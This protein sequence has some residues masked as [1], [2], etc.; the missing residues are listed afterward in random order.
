MNNNKAAIIIPFYKDQLSA[1]EAIAL[2]QC[3]KLLSAYNIIAIKPEKL[4]LPVSVT[5]Y[6]FY[7]V[8]SFNDSYFESV[9]GYNR[10]MLSAE[11]YAAFTAYEYMLIHQLDAFVFKDE[12]AYWCSQGFDYIGAP[13]INRVKYGWFKSVK[14]SIQYYIHT[15]YNIVN[16]GLPTAKQLEYKVGNGGFSLRRVQVFHE[17][18][19][20]YRSTIEI[21]NSND[22]HYFNEDI[23]WSIEV[24]RKRRILKKPSYKQALKFAFEMYPNRALEI[25]NNELPF[26]CHAWDLNIEFWRPIFS[27]AGYRV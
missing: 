27:A 13:W 26:G 21:Y 10:L 14:R 25:N 16:N 24:N 4:N 18:C 20:K 23:F 11:F 19:I 6:P 15:R 3:F 8:V 17:L 12:L 1:Y 5:N 7:K 2:Q 9:Q 22:H